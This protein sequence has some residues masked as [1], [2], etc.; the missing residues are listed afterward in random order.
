MSFLQFQKTSFRTFLRVDLLQT[1]SNELTHHTVSF[2]DLYGCEA[3]H[4]I[5]GTEVTTAPNNL[6]DLVIVSLDLMDTPFV[7]C[8]F[9]FSCGHPSRECEMNMAHVVFVRLSG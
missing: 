3:V 1:V 9:W 4:W 7:R 2:H 6:C 8:P 5:G